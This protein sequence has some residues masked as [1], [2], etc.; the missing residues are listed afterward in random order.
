MKV[1]FAADHAGFDLKNSLI[2]FVRGE[3]GIE[4]EDCGAYEKDPH[5]D[6]PEII[7]AACNC[8][9][10]DHAAG[11]ESRAIILGGSGQGEA[12]AAN[13]FPGIRAA[14][15]YGD[16]GAQIDAAG[17]SFD[18]IASVRE[19]NN[20]NVLSLGARF[21]TDEAAKQAVRT[22]LATPFSGEDR[23]KRRI[24]K[25]DSLPNTTI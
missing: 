7:A 15:Y 18:M 11:E 1:Y 12:I 8:M 16:A 2:T 22:W 13:R 25:L 5:D 3:L 23:H 14:V 9:L 6:Y 17:H 10:R 4:V 21:L 19:H 24:D 20:A